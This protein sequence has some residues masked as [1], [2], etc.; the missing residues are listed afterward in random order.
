MFKLE[1]SSEVLVCLQECQLDIKSHVHTNTMSVELKKWHKK[2][3]AQ[4]LFTAINT[5][6]QLP[7]ATLLIQSLQWPVCFDLLLVVVILRVKNQNIKIDTQQLAEYNESCQTRQ[8]HI[9]KWLFTL[10][11]VSR[12]RVESVFIIH[13]FCTVKDYLVSW[14]LHA[15]VHF[16]ARHEIV[17]DRQKKLILDKRNQNESPHERKS[18][19][20]KPPWDESVIERHTW[21]HYCILMNRSMLYKSVICHDSL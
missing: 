10:R 8:H 13:D 15:W 2:I 16:L 20:N 4:T 14:H 3:K 21:Q 18:N 9:P 7:W 11:Y 17:N 12:R 5:Q 1:R 19:P 6:H